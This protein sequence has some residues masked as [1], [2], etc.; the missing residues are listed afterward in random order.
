MSLLSNITSVTSGFGDFIGQDNINIFLS[1]HDQVIKTLEKKFGKKETI[2]LLAG[3]S[4][5][6]VNKYKYEMEE[7]EIRISTMKAII[8]S[9]NEKIITFWKE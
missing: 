5:Y 9:L 6:C 1:K 2:Q 7:Q 8:E 4:D 3:M